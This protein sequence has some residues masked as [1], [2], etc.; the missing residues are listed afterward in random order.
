MAMG[1]FGGES[2]RTFVMVS[3]QNWRRIS[4]IV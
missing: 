2:A 3:R 1:S 4:P